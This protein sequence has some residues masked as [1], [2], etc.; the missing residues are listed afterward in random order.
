M[1]ELE[2]WFIWAIQSDQLRGFIYV[3]YVLILIFWSSF[4]VQWTTVVWDSDNWM[5]QLPKPSSSCQNIKKFTACMP[6]TKVK[7]HVHL[8]HIL[9]VVKWFWKQSHSAV[10]V[11]HHCCP[12]HIKSKSYNEYT[13]WKPRTR[14]SFWH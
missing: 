7:S 3:N 5:G 9:T 1:H 13:M 12:L 10:A 11:P 6:W 8:C 14:P 2:T 4:D